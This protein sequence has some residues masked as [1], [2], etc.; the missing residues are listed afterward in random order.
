MCLLM[1]LHKRDLKA[2]AK[3]D[4]CGPFLHDFDDL[5]LKLSQMQPQVFKQIQIIVTVSCLI[6]SCHD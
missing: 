3:T 5:I 6:I 1:L 2:R 4:V